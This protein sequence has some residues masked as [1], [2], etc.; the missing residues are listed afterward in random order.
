MGY[1]ADYELEL[2][3]FS[4]V[5]VAAICNDQSEGINRLFSKTV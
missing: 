1:S 4:K 2:L 3:D 5:A